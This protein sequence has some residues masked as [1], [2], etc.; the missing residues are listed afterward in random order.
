MFVV[1]QFCLGEVLEDDGPVEAVAV[2]V[3]GVVVV[4]VFLELYQIG[5][6]FLV[7]VVVDEL[8]QRFDC[9]DEGDGEAGL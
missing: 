8:S 7:G 4:V 2:A 6:E 5:D 3:D 9:R 1:V